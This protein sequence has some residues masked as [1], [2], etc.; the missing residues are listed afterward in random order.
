M[1][2]HDT[3]FANVC[4]L[5]DNDIAA[6]HHQPKPLSV[7]LQGTTYALPDVYRRK[8]NKVDGKREISDLRNK[9][10]HP[11]LT[12]KGPLASDADVVDF[13][14]FQGVAKKDTHNKHPI[15]LGGRK[16]GE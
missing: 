4:C 6:G 11:L 15:N 3:S 10:Q 12:L 5:R 13:L 16:S 8:I 14:D 1:L 2:L 9:A 7:K